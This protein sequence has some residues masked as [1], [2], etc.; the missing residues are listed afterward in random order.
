MPAES[1]TIVIMGATGDLARRKLIP[2]LFELRCNGGCPR[3]MNLVGFSRTPLTHE[4]FRQMVWES[5]R[6][7][8]P[9]ALRTDEWEDFAQHLHYVTGSLD[10]LEDL[11]APEGAAG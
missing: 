10:S 4:G 8:G 2:A 6:E 5:V 1:I 3:E 9:L 11:G 7:F